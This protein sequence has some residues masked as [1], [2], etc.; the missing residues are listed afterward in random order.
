MAKKEEKIQDESLDKPLQFKGEEVKLQDIKVNR[1]PYMLEKDEFFII[2]KSSSE[3]KDWY[4]RFL[5]IGIGVLLTLASKII[6]ILYQ[7]SNAKSAAE[8]DKIEFS[9][10]T[11]E[12]ISLLLAFGSSLIFYIISLSVKSDK[13]KL[14]SRIK[15]HF[16][17]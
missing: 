4:K 13:D 5:Q 16:K 2:T 7:L 11:W 15:E 9:L 17:K 12:I 14:I 10:K 8:K 3:L 1:T 6:Y